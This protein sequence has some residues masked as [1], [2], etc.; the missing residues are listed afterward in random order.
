MPETSWEDSHKHRSGIWTG[1]ILILVAVAASAIIYHN[2]RDFFSTVKFHAGPV[3]RTK[4]APVRADPGP[5]APK[6][7]SVQAVLSEP[8]V[9]AVPA[10]RRFSLR[11]SVVMN[12]VACSVLGRPDLRIHLSLSLFFDDPALRRDILVRRDD[13]AIM[14]GKVVGEKELEAVKID[15]I[16]P[17]LL[18]AMNSVFETAVLTGITIRAIR[19]EK[20][21]RR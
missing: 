20:V 10:P 14:A 3:A 1:V 17:V 16:T 13:L 8:E 5:E 11:D 19:V 15:Q 6:P 9:R 7:V 2:N 21:R 18:S 12:D 4:T